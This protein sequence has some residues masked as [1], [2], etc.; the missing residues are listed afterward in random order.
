[1]RYKKVAP[2]CNCKSDMLA[3]KSEMKWEFVFGAF[4]LLSLSFSLLH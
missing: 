1:M 4:K 3:A 2:K